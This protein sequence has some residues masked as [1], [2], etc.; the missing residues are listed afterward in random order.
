MLK[1]VLETK[2][3]KPKESLAKNLKRID[4]ALPILSD[5]GYFKLM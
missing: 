1:P 2:T 3:S 4:S 5:L